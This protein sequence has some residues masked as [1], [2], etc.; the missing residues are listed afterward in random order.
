[1]SWPAR[2]ISTVSGESLF[3]A[4][5][6]RIG[7]RAERRLPRRSL[8]SSQPQIDAWRAT[9]AYAIAEAGGLVRAS[10]V[11]I[12][13][14]QFFDLLTKLVLQVADQLRYRAVA[15]LLGK[16]PAPCELGLNRLFFS[17]LVHSRMTLDLGK[18]S[19]QMRRSSVSSQCA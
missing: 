18:G 13:A 4:V 10:W 16:F 3:D 14:F 19:K 11:W 8:I 17:T 7:E 9:A 15:E 5:L 12:A 2:I 1:M 6:G